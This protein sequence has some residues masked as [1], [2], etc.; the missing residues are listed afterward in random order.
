MSRALPRGQATPLEDKSHASPAARPLGRRVAD[1]RRGDRPGRPGHG[2][3][4]VQGADAAAGHR[5]DAR[6]RDEA[7]A[8]APAAAAPTRR[9]CVESGLSGIQSLN[10]T[11]M[12]FGRAFAGPGS[13]R[14]AHVLLNFEAVDYEATV[15]VNGV[16]VGHNVG[17][18]F[19]FTVDVTEHVNWGRDNKLFVFVHDPTDADVIPV[20]KQTRNPSHIFYRS[21]SGI[22]QTVWLER[23]PSNRIT[24]LDVS[25]GMDGQVK[26]TAHT[27]AKQGTE[28]KVA[29]VDAGGRAVAE[30]WGPSDAE[31]TFSVGSPRLWSPA[32]PTLYNLTLTM[33]DDQVHSYTGFRTVSAGL[34][35]GV[36]RPLLNGEFVFL[37]GTLDQGFWP[38]GLYTP[39]SRDAM[40]YDLRMLKRLGFN[41]VR[42]H[43]KVE[44]DLFYRACDEMGLLVVQD[45]PSLPADGN[46][47]PNP[48]QQAEFQRQLEVLVNEHKSYTSVVIWVWGQLRG[49]PYPEEKLT[50][51]V[52]R[53]DASRLIDS[54]TGWN[55]HGFGDFSDNHHYANPQC[56]TP[57]Y[58][59]ASSPYDPRRIGFQGEFGGIGHNV[60]IEHLWNVQQAIDT[61]NQ[62]YEVNAD[63]DAY[64][65]RAS[66]LF[67]ELAEQV[68]RYA[69]SGA[70]WTQ[71]TDVEGEVNGLYTYDRRVL[72]PSVGQWQADIRR[73]YDAA[74]RRGG[75]RP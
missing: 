24:Q 39:P 8:G 51:V 64:N 46:R 68:E 17:G 60:S 40:V 34:V 73:L 11:H 23:A 69:C 58:S 37:F 67:R 16:R 13:W 15:F 36:Q 21:C 9:P 19:R 14:G 28:V 66:V 47:P 56:G 1:A 2:G 6:G 10:S 31:F 35:D 52:R 65:Y 50:E 57:F 45:M 74:Y 32:S 70:V 38:D 54:V 20:G 5:L 33:G 18:Y 42:K 22:W 48:A 62:T 27:S 26:V 71:T 29:V 61:I 53:L 44:P 59:I 30:A 55:D 41:M 49:P 12:W 25:A 75:A 4:A 63:L 3:D 7:V 72:R 43:V